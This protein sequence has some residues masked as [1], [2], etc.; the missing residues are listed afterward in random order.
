MFT[1]RCRGMSDCWYHLTHQLPL[2]IVKE[3]RRKQQTFLV[4]AKCNTWTSVWWFAAKTQDRIQLWNKSYANRGKKLSFIWKVVKSH[5]T[6][7]HNIFWKNQII[8]LSPS[9]LLWAGRPHVTR[10]CGK[11][12]GSGVLIRI[13]YVRM[14]QKRNLRFGTDLVLTC[15]HN[16]PL[17]QS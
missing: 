6:L 11:L 10:H 15:P 13:K 9:R 16:T 17:S 7:W 3:G 8:P 12:G 2:N 1:R 4:T 14:I 5:V